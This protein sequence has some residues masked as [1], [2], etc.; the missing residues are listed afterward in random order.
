M[1][2]SST[3]FSNS[4]HRRKQDHVVTKIPTFK[5]FHH[6]FMICQTTKCPFPKQIV[7]LNWA[8]RYVHILR[9]GFT[10]YCSNFKWKM[11]L[12]KC[13]IVATFFNRNRW[14]AFVSFNFPVAILSLCDNSEEVFTFESSQRKILWKG[15]RKLKSSWDSWFTIYVN[16]LQNWIQLLF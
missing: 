16:C 6:R 2:L 5:P 12:C 7:E 1:R 8:G 15:T 13:F 14:F 9:S 11:L 4:T 10:I 3:C